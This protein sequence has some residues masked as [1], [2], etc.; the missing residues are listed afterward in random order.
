MKLVRKDNHNVAIVATLERLIG[1]CDF[2]DYTRHADGT[3]ELHY[4]GYTEVDWD[5]QETAT[6][7]GQRV[8]ID[9]HGN[10]LLESEIVELVEDEEDEEEEDD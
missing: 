4:D 2:S 9:E 8:F 3:L 10:E 6:D 5:S 7:H 1:T